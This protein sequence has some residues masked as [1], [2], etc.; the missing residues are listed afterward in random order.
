MQF[1]YL[2]E[3]NP[4]CQQLTKNEKQWLFI[5]NK[6]LFVGHTWLK[7]FTGKLGSDQVATFIGQSFG[8]TTIQRLL[9]NFVS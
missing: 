7:Y 9:E 5:K 8:G 6:K 2:G 1:K 3:L 4:M